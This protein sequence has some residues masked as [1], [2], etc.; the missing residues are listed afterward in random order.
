MDS[1]KRIIQSLN[2][3]KLEDLNI[4]ETKNITPYFDYAIIVTANSS[5][6]LSA[7]VSKLKKDTE[8]NKIELRGI[9]GLEGG[10]WVLIDFNDVIVNIFIEEERAKYDLDKLWRT[11]PQ[12]EYNTLL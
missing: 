10:S 1:L 12:I 4:Y 7:A 2:E 3:T 9:E 6:Q 5:R 8:D 11:L